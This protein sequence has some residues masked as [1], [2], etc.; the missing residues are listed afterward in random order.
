MRVYIH[1]FIYMIYYYS[2]YHYCIVTFVYC[3]PNI[4]DVDLGI[5]MVRISI[6]KTRAEG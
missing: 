2:K 6:K 4:S 5:V 3:Q 1:I